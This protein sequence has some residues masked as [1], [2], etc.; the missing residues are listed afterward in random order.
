MSDP[1]HP[2]GIGP[3]NWRWREGELTVTRSICWS[4]PGCHGGCGVLLYVDDE[5]RLVKVEGDPANPFNQGALCPRGLASADTIYHP[6]RLQHPL[7]RAGARGEGRWRRA[8]WDEALDRIAGEFLAIRREQGPESVLFLK[9]TARDISPYISR[10]AYSFGS[11]N[12]VACGP[13]S[14]NACFMPRQSLLFAT[15][16]DF[17][18]A[19]CSQHHAAR[20]DDPTWRRPET[21]LL[22]GSNAVHSNPDGFLGS[23]IVRC[24]QRGS[25]LVVADPR[26][27]WLASRARH[28]LPL[29]PG[30]DV[31]LAL[32]FLHVI[33]DE[34]LHDADFVTRWTH[35][36]DQLAARVRPCTP[37]W[38]AEK[39]GVAPQRIAAAARFVGRSRPLAVQWGLGIDMQRSATAAAQ[40]VSAIW[41]VLGQVDVPGG[42]V[43]ARHP[44]GIRRR[45]EREGF[46]RIRV[47][48]LGLERYP[49][50]AHGIPYGQGDSM[51]DQLES[52]RPYPIQ[53]AWV[54]STGLLPGSFADPARALRLLRGLRFVAMADLFMTPG[55]TALADVL[56]PVCSFAERDGLRHAFYQLSAIN[57][58]IEPLGESRSD[59][60]ICLQLGRRLAPEA[61]P[62]DGVQQ[63][64]SQMTH[65]AGVEFAALRE[66]QPMVPGLRYRRHERG[67]L[68]AD[69]EPGFETPTG[70]IE[71]YSTELERC[72]LDPLPGWQEP[73]YDPARQP[74][75]CRDYPL[76]L[77]TGA[78]VPVFFN[79]E[80]RNVPAL[81]AFN[82]HPWVELHPDDAAAAGLADG[83]W[84]W[85][86]THY[87]R[88]KRKLRVTPEL[89]PGCAHA[90]ASWWNPDGG[91][92]ERQGLFDLPELCTNN[93]LPSQ[94]Q[95]DSGF[96]YPFRAMRCRVVPA[97]P[98]GEGIDWSS[99]TGLDKG[100]AP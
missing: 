87:G 99:V 53:A 2:R 59:M 67:E 11:P 100:G 65:P 19:D 18:V 8:S 82:P 36:F 70:R 3:Q 31:A 34:G 83:A 85:V 94:L 64:F 56:L 17:Q 55:A 57:K 86:E 12:F 7:I 80:H 73:W 52:G 45:G 37:I 33:I 78:R 14:G 91:P 54:Q 32:A 25:Q 89:L 97:E 69:G 13:A 44:Y 29:R 74:E 27:T 79:S 51:L 58:A 96:G 72:G 63:L 71:L 92:S 20:Y 23:W 76:R 93:L 10:L 6:D 75:L 95:G 40:A 5:G 16:G 62:W 41:T 15:A 47:P 48:K 42:M 46:P 28:W 43:V 26:Q 1:L 77:I 98:P 35:G 22:W 9:G 50:F 84:G 61:W 24:A 90:Q 21:I 66:R 49:L 68:R 60:E 39:T 30:S 4:A 38:A 88:C 81:R